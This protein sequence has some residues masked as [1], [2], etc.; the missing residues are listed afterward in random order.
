[1]KKLCGQHNQGMHLE[2]KKG[3]TMKNFSEF[4]KR[5]NR[6]FQAFLLAAVML[7]MAACAHFHWVCCYFGNA[8]VHVRADCR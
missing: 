2:D 8:P 1:M 7:S 5:F 6:V 4:P 3:A